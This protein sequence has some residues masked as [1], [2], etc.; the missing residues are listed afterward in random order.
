MSTAFYR[1]LEKDREGRRLG[2]ELA[3]EVIRQS[4]KRSS[5]SVSHDDDDHVRGAPMDTIYESACKS[6]SAQEPRSVF[7]RQLMKQL[8]ET[9][10]E[11]Q[12]TKRRALE[13]EMELEVNKLGPRS[14]S[15]DSDEDIF[16]PG[17][18]LNTIYE[19]DN[20]L[21][22]CCAQA[23]QSCRKSHNICSDLRGLY[24]K[25]RH[26]RFISRFHERLE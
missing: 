20:E 22:E 1:Q 17:P 8:H 7:I 13:A 4:L 24:V 10:Y 3:M 19:D 11:L 16:I 25:I 15:S 21:R 14:S 6:A 26:C 2:N 5:A 23:T 12:E 9:Q 18:Q